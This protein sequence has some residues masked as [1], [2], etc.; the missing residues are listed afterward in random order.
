L[1][2]DLVNISDNSAVSGSLCCITPV[3]ALL[4][5]GSSIAAPTPV[6]FSLNAKAAKFV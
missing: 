6:K 3:I 4:A 5:G 2:L 1:N